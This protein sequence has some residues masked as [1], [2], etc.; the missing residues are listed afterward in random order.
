MPHSHKHNLIRIP[1]LL[2]T[3]WGVPGCIIGG[4]RP[5][6]TQIV[7][8]S[9][10]RSEGYVKR[11]HVAH[12]ISL[13]AVR[14]AIAVSEDAVAQSLAALA[15]EEFSRIRTALKAADRAAAR[16][17]DA[18]E[19]A[20]EVSALYQKVLGLAADIDAQVRRV[21]ALESGVVAGSKA[22]RQSKDMA[23]DAKKLTRKSEAIAEELK[24][25]WLLVSPEP[26]RPAATA[27]GASAGLPS[28]K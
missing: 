23:A 14:N 20:A 17:H 26:D 21:R 2:L 15:G 9:A 25:D 7:S 12:Q 27:T 28:E 4:V 13:N 19:K 6:T 5:D 18:T 24:R 1:L 16:L 22:A 8:Q 10:T 11:A 3:L